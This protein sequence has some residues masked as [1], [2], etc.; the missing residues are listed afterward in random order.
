MI[1]YTKTSGTIRIINSENS[2]T[3][4]LK[5]F[6]GSIDYVSRDCTYLIFILHGTSQ[7]N[8]DIELYSRS[9]KLDTLVIKGEGSLGVQALKATSIEIK[10]DTVASHIEGNVVKLSGCKVEGYIEPEP[11]IEPPD[12]TEL[13]NLV[14]RFDLFDIEQY[15]IS[16]DGKDVLT[17]DQWITQEAKDQFTY[18]LSRAKDVLYDDAATQEAVDQAAENLIS[19]FENLNPQW[20]R[21]I[22]TDKSVLYETIV[23][24]RMSLSMYSVSE[25]GYDIPPDVQWIDTEEF[26][27]LE[28]VLSEATEIYEDTS[29]TQSTVD[30]EVQILA[31][32]IDNL[33]PVW[34]KQISPEY[35]SPELKQQLFEKLE[36]CKEILRTYLISSDG[37]DIYDT[38]IWVTSYLYHNLEFTVSVGD[39]IYAD[40][41]AS[42]IRTENIIRSLDI[43]VESLNPQYG[44]L[45][46]PRRY[47]PIPDEVIDAILSGNHSMPDYQENEAILLYRVEDILSGNRSSL[48]QSQLRILDEVIDAILNKTWQ[49]APTGLFSNLNRKIQNLNTKS[50]LK[51]SIFR[52]NNRN[53]LE[54]YSSFVNAK[55]HVWLTDCTFITSGYDTGISA[56]YILIDNSKCDVQGNNFAFDTPNAISVEHCIDIEYLQNSFKSLSLVND[57]FGNPKDF[58]YVVIKDKDGNVSKIASR[59][60]LYGYN[61]E[62]SMYTQGGALVSGN[63]NIYAQPA[64][65]Y[66]IFKHSTQYTNVDLHR[67]INQ[68]GEIYKGR[69]PNYIS[70]EVLYLIVNS[71]WGGQSFEW[72][73]I[74]DEVINAICDGTYVYDGHPHTSEPMDP[75]VVEAILEG[76]YIWPREN[77][78]ELDELRSRNYDLGIYSLNSYRFTDILVYDSNSEIC[79]DREIP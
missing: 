77:G 55:G 13:Q 46:D 52:N 26:E 4:I 74:S 54:N 50:L 72:E 1:S 39:E 34:G 64:T 40:T 36:S 51:G 12:K 49:P 3:A 15:F 16:I 11:V 2:C 66:D 14:T 29:V 21:K 9:D 59:R 24:A 19:A 69:R 5:N 42:K 75:S 57:E 23:R 73:A 71:L 25:D 43:A 76:T 65:P 62:S 8:S 79:D 48:S 78:S 35:A 67:W 70:D 58:I 17:T 60:K 45:E 41:Q 31:Y 28:A 18:A 27:Y 44:L 6:I 7:I 22:I 38:Q 33:S 20:G 32:A 47:Q 37:L 63:Q 53:D 56:P 30:N 61:V 10:S 68:N